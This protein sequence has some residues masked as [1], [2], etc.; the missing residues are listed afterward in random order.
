M[1]KK[2]TIGSSQVVT[3]TP[4]TSSIPHDFEPVSRRKQDEERDE[5]YNH[6]GDKQ[7]VQFARDR[8]NDDNPDDSDDGDVA[9]EDVLHEEDGN[10]RLD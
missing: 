1:I 2:T 4:K 8:F 10:L 3:S 5:M 9:R 7:N 6:A